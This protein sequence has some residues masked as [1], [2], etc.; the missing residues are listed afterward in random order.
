MIRVCFGWNPSD[1]LEQAVCIAWLDSNQSSSWNLGRVCEES[2]FFP[3]GFATRCLQ[4]KE[5]IEHIRRMQQ[6]VPSIK[7]WTND[8]SGIS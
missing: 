4:F 6:H 1:A 2:L 3:A 5:S 7:S 8:G